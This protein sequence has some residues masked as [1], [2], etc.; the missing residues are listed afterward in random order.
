VIVINFRIGFAPLFVAAV[1]ACLLSGCGGSDGPPR[2]QVSGA[3]TYDGKPVPKGHVTFNP[4]TAQGNS[5][6]GGGAPI[7]NGKYRTTADMG[8]VGGPHQVKIVGYDGVPVN[9]EGEELPD[10]TPLFTPYQTTVD[11]P[12]E[13]TEQNFEI[14]AAGQ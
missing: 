7:V 2:Y 6:P 14:P 13:K 11:F 8:V 3:V 9:M 10:G 4:D 5:G 1:A 12:E